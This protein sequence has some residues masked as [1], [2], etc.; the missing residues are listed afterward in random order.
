MGIKIASWLEGVVHKL[1]QYFEISSSLILFALLVHIEGEIF[2]GRI[3]ANSV[4]LT[5]RLTL[6]S[7]I[8][9][10]DRY[11]VGFS[12]SIGQFIPGRVHI[13][14][15]ASP[16]RQKFYKGALARIIDHVIEIFRS[17]FHGACLFG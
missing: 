5:Q 8:N 17:Q 6:G 7:A 2:N 14:A 15:V 10:R 9:I 13:L 4:F 12:I 11:Q 1:L 3:S 16:W